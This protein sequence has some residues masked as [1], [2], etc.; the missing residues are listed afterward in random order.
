VAKIF[1]DQGECV[2]FV[3]SVLQISTSTW[4]ERLR[5]TKKPASANRPPRQSQLLCNHNDWDTIIEEAL[6]ELRQ[7]PY[8]DV[9]GYR[10][11]TNYL[12]RDYNLKVNHKRVYRLY[13]AKGMTLPYK[14]KNKRRGKKICE[15]RNVTSPNMLWQFDIKYGFIDG[16]NRFFYLC[17]FVDVFTREVVDYYVGLRCTGKD[18]LLQLEH[19][20]KKKNINA[21]N[22]V[23]RSD[24][25]PQMTSYQFCKKIHDIGVEHEYTPPSTPNLN[26]YVESFFSIIDRELFNGRQFYS[27]GDAYDEVRKFITHYNEVRIHGSLKMMT[28]KEFTTK[29]FADNNEK[30]LVA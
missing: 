3:L 30:N 7:R 16:E 28:P 27:Y 17:A 4:Y 6:V 24:N 15:N 23:I 8:F 2:E 14:R 13:K 9:I 1:I 19:A 5:M 10:K 21:S 12:R 22:L 20:L 25:G 26:A 29:F 11:L 18:I